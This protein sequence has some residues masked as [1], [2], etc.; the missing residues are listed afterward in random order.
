MAKG[1]SIDLMLLNDGMFRAVLL[2]APEN[3]AGI[4]GGACPQI[5]SIRPDVL[6]ERFQR[7]LGFTPQTLGRIRAKI[8][9]DPDHETEIPVSVTP[10]QLIELGFI[11]I[12][13][14]SP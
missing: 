11:G 12:D 8:K 13:R 1:Y 2:P 3:I 6:N 14:I 9:A 10:D 7:V 5:P 4:G